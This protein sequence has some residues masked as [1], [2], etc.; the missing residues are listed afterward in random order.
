MWLPRFDSRF[1]F[2]ACHFIVQSSMTMYSI[3]HTCILRSYNQSIPFEFNNGGFVFIIYI[4]HEINIGHITIVNHEPRFI[5]VHTR[6]IIAP[7]A[8]ITTVRCRCVVIWTGARCLLFRRW[9]HHLLLGQQSQPRRF[10]LLCYNVLLHQCHHLIIVVYARV[11]LCVMYPFFHVGKAGCHQLE[12]TGAGHNFETW[13]T[14]EVFG[15]WSNEGIVQR[16][17]VNGIDSILRL[18][19]EQFVATE[20]EPPFF[21]P[22]VDHSH[23][24]E[25]ATHF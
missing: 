4:L 24:L 22:L 7:K 25:L 14:G 3:C 18:V 6:L 12:D 8:L 17:V 13:N 2:V 20:D 15:R 10:H 21:E 11:L 16:Y 5:T 23:L 19:I 1:T 9:T